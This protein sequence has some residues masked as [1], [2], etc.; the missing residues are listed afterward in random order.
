MNSFE[1]DKSVKR[2]R[3][4]HLGSQFENLRW[5]DNDYVASSSAKLSAMAHEACVACVLRKKYKEKKLVKK[6][7]SC[8]P[9]KFGAHKA[10][11]NMTTNTDELK[12][13]KLVGMLKEEEMERGNS[14]I[15]AMSTTSRSIALV[16]DKNGERPLNFEDFMGMLAWNFGKKMNL[17]GGRNQYDRHGSDNGNDRRREE[18]SSAMS[19]KALV[20]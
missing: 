5:S 2:T 1:G 11:L 6:L 10:V 13:D 9:T 14:L 16:A 19:V 15:S 20:I 12:F 3:L 4:D 7:Q 18:V 8:L 17:S